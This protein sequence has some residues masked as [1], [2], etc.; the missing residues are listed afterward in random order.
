M[1]TRDTLSV[2]V[3]SSAATAAGYCWFSTCSVH[4]LSLPE[5]HDRRIFT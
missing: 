2:T 4:A 5:L 1:A 3:V